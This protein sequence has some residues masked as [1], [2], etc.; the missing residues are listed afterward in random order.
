MPESGNMEPVIYVLGWH[1]C[2][3]HDEMLH[4]VGFMSMLKIAFCVPRAEAVKLYMRNF[5]VL[6]TCNH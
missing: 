5:A 1:A 3:R 4:F 6:Q 2:G